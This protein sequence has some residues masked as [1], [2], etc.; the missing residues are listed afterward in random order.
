MCGLYISMAQIIL[1][2]EDQPTGKIVPSRPVSPIELSIGK[3]LGLSM[4]MP[5]D[6]ILVRKVDSDF[7]GSMIRKVQERGGFPAEH[8]RWEHAAVYIGKGKICE[9]NRGGVKFAMLSKYAASHWIRVR[10]DVQLNMDRRH[11]LVI[12]ALTS[13]TLRYSFLD[14]FSLW[15]QARFGFGSVE[16]GRKLLGPQYPRS[17][18]ICSQLYADCYVHVTGKILGDLQDGISTPAALSATDTL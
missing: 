15:K 16:G 5:G 9:A 6:L 14:I 10:R 2:P 8:A 18:T 4:L 11:E 13:T 7:I 1:K 17:A 3:V 12:H